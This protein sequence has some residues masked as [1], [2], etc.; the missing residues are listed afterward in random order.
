MQMAEQAGAS[1]AAGLALAF[2]SLERA[3]WRARAVTD[4][5][6]ELLAGELSEH[7][8]IVAGVEQA[9]ELLERASASGGWLLLPADGALVLVLT[10]RRRRL[11]A[12]VLER[13][14]RD[15]AAGMSTRAIAA[16][17]DADGVRPLR[18]GSSWQHSSV[19]WLLR[20]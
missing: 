1:S 5:R 3:G 9:G 13:I 7:V 4:E 6:G 2:E 20:H 8:A 10:G 12:D 11:R 14:R 16:R 19:R 15:R 18:G 17:L